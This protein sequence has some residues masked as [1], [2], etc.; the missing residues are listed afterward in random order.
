MNKTALVIGATGLVGEEC[1]Q[2]L[3]ASPAYS[4]VITLTR[5]PSGSTN[6]KLQNLVVDFDKPERYSQ[7]LK[8]D[9]VYCAMGTTIAK[10]GSQQA[11][12]KVDYDIPL[13]VAQLALQN[14]AKKFILVSSLSANDRSPVFYSKVK[15][16]LEEAMRKLCYSSLIIFRPAILLGARNESRPGEAI[17]QKIFKAI[18]FLFSGPLKRY[19]GM[20]APVL[21]KAMVKMG[22]EENSGFRL[23][24]NEEIFNLTPA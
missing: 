12:R 10:A 4:K 17:A 6:P 15:G 14:G 20:P 13:Q 22:E 3:L 11:F 9:D 18:P 23:I 21:A 5:K 19:R 24:E 8:A 2:Q 7:Q 1:V 16:E